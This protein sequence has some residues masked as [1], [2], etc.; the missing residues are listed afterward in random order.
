MDKPKNLIFVIFGASGDLTYRKIIPSL[1][2]LEVQNLLPE[3]FAIIGASLAPLTTDTFRDKMKEG[4]KNFADKKD[5]KEDEVN[6]FIEKISYLNLK[7]SDPDEYIKLKDIL[8]E[9]DKELNTENNYIFYLAVPSVMF[10]IVA[11]NLGKVGLNDQSVGCKRILVEKPFGS[12]LSTAQKLNKELLEF[13]KEEHIF[14]IDHYLGKESVQNLFVTRFANGIFE[15]L[16]NR[17]YIDHVEITSAEKIGIEHRGRYYDNAGALRDMLQNH[18]L[19]EVSLMAMEPT[20]SLDSES[21]RNEKL[22]VI[23]ALRPIKEEEVEK[24]IIRGQYTSSTIKEQYLK[25]YREEDDINPKSRTE[26]FVAMKFYIDNWRWGGVPFYV[27][28]GKRLPTTVNE[29]V[30]HFKATPNHLFIKNKDTQTS[31]QLVIRIQPDEGMLL[32]FLVKLPGKGY[33]VKD[34]DM[35][36]YYKD[37]TD[38]RIPSAYERLLYDAMHGD[39]TLFLRDDSVEASWKYV[40]PILNAWKNNPCGKVLGYA[41]GTWGPPNADNLIEG[42][43]K[44]WRYPCK[45]LTD[46]DVYCEL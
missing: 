37:L 45:N 6:A 7:T 44:G 8:T 33:S 35:G 22:K 28:T 42:D 32:K 20:S 9:K 15:P 31:N 17:N 21:I 40:M 2:S 11:A 10:G 34:V 29:I 4:I 3:K 43:D 14:R 38:V 18:M 19:Q 36:F 5:F 26:T 39:S 46:E 27:R 12:D 41:A 1:Y 13:F 24:Y 30:I 23:Q 16:W 25:A